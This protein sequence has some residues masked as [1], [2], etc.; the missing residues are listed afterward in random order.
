MKII[1]KYPL[2][3]TGIQSIM[4]PKNANILTAQVQNDIPCL[5][6]VVE[7]EKELE[8]R[9]IITYGTGHPFTESNGKHKYI[10]TYQL[11]GGGFIGHIFE[12]IE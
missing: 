8:E 5:W 3:T 9:H 6:A 2:K 10:A 12:F 7:P 1:Y 11:A 4:M